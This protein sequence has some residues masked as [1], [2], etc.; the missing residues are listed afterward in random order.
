MWQI[1][2][3]TRLSKELNMNES[4]NSKTHTILRNNTKR[5][6]NNVKYFGIM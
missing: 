3:L 4:W 1:D 6:I 5:N 2:K